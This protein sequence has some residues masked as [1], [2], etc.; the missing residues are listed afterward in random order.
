M[1][2]NS[3]I[4]LGFILA[5]FSRCN[6]QN[7]TSTDT[8]Q[9]VAS[10]SVP[11][12]YDSITDAS[13]NIYKTV[14]IGTQVWMAENL[15]T[16]KYHD[17]ADIPLIEDA[18][19]WKDLS[20]PAY[21]WYNN[22]EAAHKT[23]YGAL[24]NWH[25][26]KT[27]KLCPIGWHVPNYDEWSVLIDYLGGEKIA[28]GKLKKMGLD[29]WKAPNK[30]A[31]NEFGFAALP[32]GFRGYDAKFIFLGEY[33]SFWSSSWYNTFSA[34][35]TGMNYKFSKIHRFDY[36]KDFGLSVRCLRND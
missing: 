25:A 17:S 24:Y 7:N 10:I 29:L 36:G 31:S 6:N 13:G 19:T 20:T 21:C 30:D 18:G 9:K 26:V 5:L 11:S 23:T 14:T 2:V 35:S 27:D 15:K 3:L 12:N 8:S 22:D 34:K 32:G 28:G 1:R 16:T 4:G 33:A